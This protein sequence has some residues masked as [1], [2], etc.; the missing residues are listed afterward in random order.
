MKNKVLILLA[1]LLVSS[2]VVAQPA[3]RNYDMIKIA[4]TR[5]DKPLKSA[6]VTIEGSK[7]K[8]AKGFKFLAIKQGFILVPEAYK[9]RSPDA[10]DLMQGIDG[11]KM[12]PTG[13]KWYCAGDCECNPR[14]CG[15]NCL[16]CSGCC[17]FYDKV[18]G[19]GGILIPDYE[20]P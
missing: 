12:M 13:I 3:L 6:H 15:R 2:F 8:A 14:K 4:D 11:F 20:T 5:G 19:G 17:D 18:R 9:A 7:L 1:F 10:K 16:Q